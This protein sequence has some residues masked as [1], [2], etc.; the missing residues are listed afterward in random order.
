[1][2]GIITA[3]ITVV[4]AQMC[5]S[6]VYLSECLAFINAQ[7][8]TIML[9]SKYCDFLQLTDAKTELMEGSNF[10]KV[11]QGIGTK[12]E[13]STQ[14]LGS[15]C[16]YRR[17]TTERTWMDGVPIHRQTILQPRLYWGKISS[18]LSE[19]PSQCLQSPEPESPSFLL[20]YV[21]LL[22]MH[23]WC[24]IYIPWS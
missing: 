23:L 8:S 12:A 13:A 7:M 4:R 21:L 24:L 5:S 1:M 9:W 11:T 20:H 15:P 3:I 18:F 17:H 14:T 6:S 22:E 19:A 10:L 16:T 2:L